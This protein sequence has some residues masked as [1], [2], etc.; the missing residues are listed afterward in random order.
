MRNIH[1]TV[2]LMSTIW[3]LCNIRHRNHFCDIFMQFKCLWELIQCVSNIG[4]I[5]RYDPGILH[6]P[7][8]IKLVF[9][10]LSQFCLTFLHS[11]LTTTPGP[12]THNCLKCN[13]II[14]ITNES[15]TSIPLFCFNSLCFFNS[16]VFLCEVVNLLKLDSSCASFVG[17]F[18]NNLREPQFVPNLLTT[19]VVLS[20][21]SAYFVFKLISLHLYQISW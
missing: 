20:H 5:F 21:P 3:L 18:E 9:H 13:R 8:I 4:I 1:L 10:E 19:S 12:K 16:L 11:A 2:G 15:S 6:L 7:K 17:S 14:F